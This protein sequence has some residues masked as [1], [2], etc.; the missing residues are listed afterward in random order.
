[1][2]KAKAL[3]HVQTLV[4]MCRYNLSVLDGPT[5]RRWLADHRHELQGNWDTVRFNWK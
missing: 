4:L 2:A 1:M 3:T 5:E